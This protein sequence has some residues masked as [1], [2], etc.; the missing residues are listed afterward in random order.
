MAGSTGEMP[1]EDLTTQAMAAPVAQAAGPQAAGASTAADP[2]EA[3]A[4]AQHMRAGEPGAA[5]PLQA[6][7]VTGVQGGLPT[8]LQSLA[9]QA[10]TRPVEDIQRSMLAAVDPNDPV[11]TMVTV[12]NLSMEATA[13]MSRLHL[14]TSLASAATSLFGT[15]LKN[16]Q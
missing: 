4:F 16:Q 11:R 7:T 12:A 13:S 9:G 1:M 3:L 2:A 8:M 15:L 5:T 10:Q 14:S 6:P